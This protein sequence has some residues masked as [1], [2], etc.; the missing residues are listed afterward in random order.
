MDSNCYLLNRCG[1]EIQKPTNAPIRS[2]TL[3]EVNI[4]IESAA[5]DLPIDL[6]EVKQLSKIAKDAQS[7]FDQALR[8]A[9]KRKV[10]GNKNLEEKHSIDQIV[11]LI[12]EA[13]NVPM[14]TLVDVERLKM[15]LSDTTSWRLD[16]QV[17]IRE[18]IDLFAALKQERMKYYGLSEDFIKNLLGVHKNRIEIRTE[19]SGN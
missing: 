9:P 4:A 15:Q 7:W 17:K 18:I 16:T 1:I 11:T 10:R 6:E 2:L 14:D 13:S 3:D 8:F 5:K 19:Q 12:D